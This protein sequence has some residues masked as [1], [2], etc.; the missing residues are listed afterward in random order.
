MKKNFGIVLAIALGL[1]ALLLTI[2]SLAGWVKANPFAQ[3]ERTGAPTIVSY[4][5][6]IW[7]GDTPYNG[8]GYFKFAIIDSFSTQTWSNDGNNPPTTSVPL[9]VDNG[10]F[11]VNLGAAGMAPIAE[12][13]FP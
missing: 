2:G 6:Q 4:Q 10:L 11:S 12:F 5:G 7:D 8:T 1:S 13:C 3:E 9:T